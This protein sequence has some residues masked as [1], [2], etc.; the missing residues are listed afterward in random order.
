MI[1]DLFKMGADIVF[2]C[3]NN[4]GNKNGTGFTTKKYRAL[5]LKVSKYAKKEGIG[6]VKAADLILKGEDHHTFFQGLK[7]EKSEGTTI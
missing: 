4:S 7:F 3:K 6:L 2:S 1:K 5:K